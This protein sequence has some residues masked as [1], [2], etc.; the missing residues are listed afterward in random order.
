MMCLLLKHRYY[1]CFEMKWTVEL[2]QLALK[3]KNEDGLTYNQVAEQLGTTLSSIKHKIRRLQQKQNLDKYKHTKEKC[4]LAQKYVPH[5]LKPVILET[6]AGF[7]GMTEYYSKYGHTTS[8]ELKE[9]R[10]KAIR[11]KRLPNNH[12]IQCD[13]EEYLYHLISL[14]ERYD[15]IDLDPYGYPSRFFPHVFKLMT[16]GILFVTLPMIGVAQINK[17]TIAHLA[18]FWG[19]DYREPSIYLDTVIKRMEE[20][21]FMH[22]KRITVLEAPKFGRIY[23]LAIKVETVPLNELVGLKINR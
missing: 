6:H 10:V 11:N 21:A 23:R 8:L 15:V 12:V 19:V 5:S 4:D 14:K 3:L 2:E 1:W 18:S 9:E 13:S 17:I 22:K 7:G 16:D 20:Y